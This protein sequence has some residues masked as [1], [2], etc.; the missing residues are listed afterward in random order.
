LAFF[1]QRIV[2]WF[3]KEDIP[4]QTSVDIVNESITMEKQSN[5]YVYGVADT[6]SANT[7][8]RRRNNVTAV[9]VDP[10]VT[11]IKARA[12]C[13]WHSLQTISLPHTI[14]TIGHGVFMNCSSL[15]SITLPSGIT[16]LDNNVFRGCSSLA[17]VALPSGITTLGNSVFCGCSSLASITLPSGITTLDH[18][19]FCGCSSLA[20]ITLPSGITTIGDNVFYGCS[21][22]VSIRLPSS[23]TT[24]GYSVFYG[25]SFLTSVHLP[26]NLL[27][28]SYNAFHRCVKLSAIEASSFSTT[29]INNN[30]VDEFKDFLINAG[31]S[32]SDPCDILSDHQQSSKNYYL[33][34]DWK[35]W[36]RTRGDDGRFPLFTAAAKGV[37]WSKVKQIFISN[38]PVVNEIDVVTGLPLSL[39]AATGPTCDIES[40]YNLLKECP[41]AV[42][43]TNQGHNLY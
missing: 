31:F 43:I 8:F 15:A 4:C 5:E 34:Y 14:T 24:I 42:T 19:V 6:L 41:S 26:E 25:C 10:A 29:T 12:F 39:L 36:A 9:N 2:R 13:D 21:S 28:I 1:L 22:L 27:S 38:M 3:G 11:S 30:T 20:S 37:Q 17:S 33:Y 16:A 7:S 32:N 35:R 40:V 23:I 18:R